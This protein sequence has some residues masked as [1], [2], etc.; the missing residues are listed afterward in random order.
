MGM[1][2]GDGYLAVD[3]RRRIENVTLVMK[4]SIKQAAYLN[5]KAD[6]LHKYLGGKRPSVREFDNS[7]FPGIRTEKT[8]KSFRI[9][10]KW[11]YPDGK[12]KVSRVL[13][14]LTP[15]GLAIWYMD[16]GGLAIKKR[17]GLVHAVDLCINCQCKIDEAHTICDAIFTKFGIR[18][19]PNLNNGNYRIRCG[20]IEA[21]RF[22]EIVNEFIIPEMQYKIA[23]LTA[24]TKTGRRLT[25]WPAMI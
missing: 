25:H 9:I 7:G 12:K 22:V 5:H 13:R 20:T 16:D 19:K 21:R 4:H 8:N 17:N 24:S 10:R 3:R 18:F 1:S 15:H 14:W 23:P 11:L 6:L 2:I